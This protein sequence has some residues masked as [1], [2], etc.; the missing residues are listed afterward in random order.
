MLR[1]LAVSRGSTARISKFGSETRLDGCRDE[2]RFHTRCGCTH[3]TPIGIP[4]MAKRFGSLSGGSQPD[5]E[6]E[7][8]TVYRKR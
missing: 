3:R 6:S 2:N 5:V 4:L 8:E 7:I 1:R